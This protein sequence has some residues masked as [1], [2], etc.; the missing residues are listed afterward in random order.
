MAARTVPR[1]DMVLDELRENPKMMSSTGLVMTNMEDMNDPNAYDGSKRRRASIQEDAIFNDS[2]LNLSLGLGLSGEPMSGYGGLAP[3]PSVNWQP[4]LQRDT[5][6][7]SS[8]YFVPILPPGNPSMPLSMNMPMS[9]VFD[10]DGQ[11]KTME[12]GRTNPDASHPN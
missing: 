11:N 8:R 9:T 2:G 7:P 4:S 1:I 10:Q 5:L 12:S 3:M 6:N